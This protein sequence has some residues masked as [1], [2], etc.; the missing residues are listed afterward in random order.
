MRS[1]FLAF[2]LVLLSPAFVFAQTCSESTWIHD[3]EEAWDTRGQIQNLDCYRNLINDMDQARTIRASVWELLDTKLPRIGYKVVGLD[4]VNA[5]LDGVDRPMV[6]ALYEGMMMMSGDPFS[7]SSAQVIIT[8]PDFLVTVKDPRVMEATTLLEALPYLD[9]VYAFIETLAPTFVNNPAN[10]YLMHSANIMARW[11]VIGESVQVENSQAFL[12][13]LESM[14]VTFFDQD[15]NVLADQPGSYLGENPLN[16]VMVVIDELRRE[17]LS[18]S[19]GDV[20]SSGSYMPPILVTEPVTYTTRYEG[21]GGQD[22][23]VS[24]TFIP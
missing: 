10:A 1:I 22:I 23:S 14:R 17:G 3:F 12:D 7:L 9:R 21:I 13:S 16:G 15:G 18:L 11:G 5:A 2:Y 8:E 24:T 20:I 4:P 6:G 19:A